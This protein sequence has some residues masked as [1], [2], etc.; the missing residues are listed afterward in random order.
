MPEMLRGLSP[1][2]HPASPEP[3]ELQLGSGVLSTMLDHVRTESPGVASGLLAGRAGH[4]SSVHPVRNAYRGSRAKHEFLP[5]PNDW[6]R[7]LGEIQVRGLAVIA[8]YLGGEETLIEPTQ[9]MG[10]AWSL[11]PGALYLAVGPPELP[12]LR[13]FALSADRVRE[14]P[15]ILGSAEDITGVMHQLFPGNPCLAFHLWMSVFDRCYRSGDR[16][17]AQRL[18]DEISK[19]YPLWSTA[20]R[21]VATRRHLL[22]SEPDAGSELQEEDRLA[23]LAKTLEEDGGEAR[24]HAAL[25]LAAL[26]QTETLRKALSHG[27]GLGRRLAA[28]ALRRCERMALPAFRITLRHKHPD[29]YVRWQA[30]EHLAAHGDVED[31]EML[32]NGLSDADVDVRAVAITALGRRRDQKAI[33]PLRDL[34]CTTDRDSNGHRLDLLARD[35]LLTIGAALQ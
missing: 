20:E 4:A 14:I 17:G 30:L 26:G 13:A 27:D 31:L 19:G 24:F 6:N 22:Q 15:V 9:D 2:K 18:L 5:D 16:H 3:A 21:A 1:Q 11:Y 7:A 35:A 12:Q 34:L 23:V 8:I 32:R 29:W 10:Q 33:A 28:G 25:A